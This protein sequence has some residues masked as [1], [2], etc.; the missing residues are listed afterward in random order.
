MSSGSA[1]RQSRLASAT[2]AEDENVL[3][4]FPNPSGATVRFGGETWDFRCI[5][6]LAPNLSRSVLAVEWESIS[7]PSFRLAA[8]EVLFAQLHP[9]H[10]RVISELGWRRA[11]AIRSI[12]SQVVIWRAW[13]AWL[14]DNDLHELYEVGAHHFDAYLQ[15]RRQDGVSAI[16]LA[17]TIKRI[18]D[19]YDYAPILTSPGYERRPWGRRTA[20]KVA[21][22]RLRRENT[23]PPITDEVFGPLVGAALHLVEH[24]DTIIAARN[25][26]I[27]MAAGRRATQEKNVR[28]C[29][30]RPNECDRR[31]Q[32]LIDRHFAQR[33]PLPLAPLRGRRNADPALHDVNLSLIAFWAGIGAGALGTPERQRLIEAAIDDLG[34]APAPLLRSFGGPHDHEATFGQVI[35]SGLVTEAVHL[36][37]A[38]CFIVVG[39]SGMRPEEITAIRRGCIEHVSLRNGDERIRLHGTVFKHRGLGGTPASWVVIEEIE[40]A[41]AVLERLA[42]AEVELLFTPATSRTNRRTRPRPRATMTISSY[43]DR[44]CEWLASGVLP[45][46]LE[47][48]PTGTRVTP[49][50]FRRT[51][52]R[53]LAFRPHGVV[54]GK[55]H[56]KHLHVLVSEG[57]YGSANSSLA[58]F[59]ADMEAELQ[60]ARLEATKERYLAYMDGSGVAGGARKV[61]GRHFEEIATEMAS[62]KGTTLEADKHLEELLADHL[63]KLHIGTVNDCW[64][65]DPAKALCRRG[66]PDASAPRP[67]ACVGDRCA[68]AVVTAVH[69]PLYRAGHE[70]VVTLRRSRKVSA[71]EKERLRAE[72]ARLEAVIEAVEG[73]P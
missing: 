20:S 55:V 67:N 24:A 70:Q 54:A 29:S 39:L 63:G 48:L 21:G 7:N 17:A 66:D 37:V 46:G 51:M 30:K 36:L 43:L 60:A 56:L 47:P 40:K 65:V 28:D 58:A 11:V 41:V 2:F 45:P 14:D 5:E 3:Q 52:A 22:V 49:R 10:P 34:L 38:A 6:G 72:Q 12:R 25:V 32:G 69:L 27:D 19:F 68:N 26:Q 50:Q 59:H 8:K 57:Y 44:F 73:Q 62:F 13:F 31:L 4:G 71:F 9:D 18:R 1:Q 33:R 53:I 35:S 16:H 64:F 23:T 15:R 42:P 61:L